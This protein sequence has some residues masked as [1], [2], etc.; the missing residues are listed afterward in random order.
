[1]RASVSIVVIGR[2]EGERLERCL[3]AVRAA[4]GCEQAEL[5]Y[6]DSNSSDNSIAVA[7][8]WGAQVIELTGKC[9]AARARS[10][11]A[12]RTSSAMPGLRS[13]RAR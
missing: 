8:G 11:R 1:M 12:A 9:S 5:I 13:A 3:G 7:Q 2:N 10:F 6:V 4:Q